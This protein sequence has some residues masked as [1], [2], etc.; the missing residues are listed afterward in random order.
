MGLLAYN[1][2]YLAKKKNDYKSAY[3]Y[4]LLAQQFNQ[5]SRSNVHFEVGLY[6]TWGRQLFSKND[7]MAA[8]T[9]FA[10]GFYRYPDNKDFLKNTFTSFYKSLQ[11]NWQR[12]DW[13][14]S[15]RLI[16]EM[17]DLEVLQERDR[18]TIKQILIN[19]Q[20]Y[21]NSKNDKQSSNQVKHFLER[22]GA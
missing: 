17:I 9:V 21:F 16:D 1:R 18:H 13:P 19:W 7:F 11:S 14:E 6:Y 3:E 8:F 15:A 2:A 4:V 22:F 12:K 10:D 20:H 5:D